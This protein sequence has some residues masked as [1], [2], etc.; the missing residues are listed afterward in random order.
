MTALLSSIFYVRSS[1][2]FITVTTNEFKPETLS[3]CKL[4]LF[5]LFYS[6]AISNRSTKLDFKI[7]VTVNFID[8]RK[9]II[10]QFSQQLNI[11]WIDNWKLIERKVVFLDLTR[12]I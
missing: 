2:D 1:N 9:R 10:F 11:S 4:F 5:D 7:A 6:L 3:D 12:V 8:I